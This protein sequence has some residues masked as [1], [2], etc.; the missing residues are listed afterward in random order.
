[1]GRKRIH[2]PKYLKPDEK[3]YGTNVGMRKHEGEAAY[4]EVKR[5]P[6]KEEL[7]ERDRQIHALHALGMGNTEIGRRLGCSRTTVYNTLNPE[8]RRRRADEF[9][10]R[11]KKRLA[12]DPEYA[13]H[14]RTLKRTYA[15]TTLRDQ[16]VAKTGVDKS[17][18]VFVRDELGR[19]KGKS[20]T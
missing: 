15:Q 7:A 11:R 6:T 19:R 18:P 17:T 14:M 10:E 16:R 2:F 12:T 1:M 5:L 20:E 8:G 13:D 3:V 9:D 4:R